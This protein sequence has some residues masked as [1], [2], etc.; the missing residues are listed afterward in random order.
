MLS[1]YAMPAGAAIH[2][3][4][5]NEILPGCVERLAENFSL[6]RVAEPMIF[7]LGKPLQ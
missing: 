6:P 7:Q 1:I 5:Q 3:I 4:D 2:R